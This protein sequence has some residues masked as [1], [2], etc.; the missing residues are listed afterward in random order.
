MGE[1]AEKITLQ[2]TTKS[3]VAA[4]ALTNALALASKSESCFPSNDKAIVDTMS[5]RH[6]KLSQVDIPYTA[7]RVVVRTTRKIKWREKKDEHHL[8]HYYNII[9]NI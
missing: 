9:N 1:R 3:G 4:V 5:F 8:E 6:W 7:V 2:C